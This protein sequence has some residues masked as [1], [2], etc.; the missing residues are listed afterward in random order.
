MV[1]VTPF[2]FSV[3]FS[4]K[5]HMRVWFGTATS[6]QKGQTRGTPSERE[7]DVRDESEDVVSCFFTDLWRL[8]G[9][10]PRGPPSKEYLERVRGH[11]R[12][13]KCPRTGLSVSRRTKS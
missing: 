13:K 12:G 9:D 10:R 3:Y 1:E 2:F 11:D 7:T 6:G 4:E 8:N 5:T